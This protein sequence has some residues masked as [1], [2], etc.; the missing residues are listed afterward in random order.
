MHKDRLI[1]KLLWLTIFAI[2]MA[3]IESAVVVYLRAIFYPDGFKFPLK[4]IMDHKIVIEVFREAATLFMLLS[5]TFLAGKTRWER[6]A[7]FM[8]SFGVWDVFYYI[9]LKVLLN[10]PESLFDW[11]ILFLIPVPWISPVIAPVSVSLLM[12]IFSIL[13]ARSIHKGFGFSPKLLSGILALSGITLILYSFMHD[14]NATLLQ[15]MPKPYH[16]DFL[17]I[18]DSLFIVA[19]LIAYIKRKGNS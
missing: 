8:F 15:H 14:V 9:W 19:F 5:V 4:A 13:I 12:I 2:A 3:F 1:S 6:F 11:D 10:W 16:Y 7:Y 18:G 17:I